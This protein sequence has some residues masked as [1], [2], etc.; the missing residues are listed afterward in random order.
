MLLLALY[1]Q[2]LNFGC[3]LLV[4]LSVVLLYP[5]TFFNGIE[6]LIDTVWGEGGIFLVFQIFNPLLRFAKQKVIGVLI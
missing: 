3:L 2:L 1:V 5:R 6:L 4:L